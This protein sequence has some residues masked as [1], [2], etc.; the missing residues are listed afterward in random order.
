LRYWNMD[1]WHVLRFGG[2][3]R[4][5]R[6]SGYLPPKFQHFAVERIILLRGSLSK[7]FDLKAELPLP[8]HRRNGEDRSG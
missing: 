4:L 2:S 8:H 1:R 6:N 5:S 3:A 7:L